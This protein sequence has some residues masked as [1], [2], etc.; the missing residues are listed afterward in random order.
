MLH[1]EGDSYEDAKELLLLVGLMRLFLR[2]PP[3][4]IREA[5]I[6]QAQQ[7]HN[8]LLEESLRIQRALRIE[9]EPPP[10]A[11]PPDR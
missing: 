2:S 10:I 11:P 5:R 8:R 6:R 7:L 9:L 1:I 4:N 3:G